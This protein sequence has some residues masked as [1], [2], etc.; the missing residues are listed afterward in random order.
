MGL[1]E[2]RCIAAKTAREKVII[3]QMSSDLIMGEDIK[4]LM[5]MHCKK[6]MWVEKLKDRYGIWMGAW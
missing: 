3:V 4:I 5:E 2:L 6:V 1:K